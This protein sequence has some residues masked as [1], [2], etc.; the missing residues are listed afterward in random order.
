M[1]LQGNMKNQLP[2]LIRWNRAGVVRTP[3]TAAPC[4]QRDAG[5]AALL[6]P[7]V[8]AFGCERVSKVLLPEQAKLCEIV[9]IIQN[10]YSGCAT[11]NCVFVTGNLSA[12]I[13]YELW[14][15]LH[16]V[17]PQSGLMLRTAAWAVSP[18][19]L[20][21]SCTTTGSPSLHSPHPWGLRPH[22]LL[23]HVQLA[24]QHGGSSRAAV[25]HVP[26]SCV[27]K[28]YGLVQ[29]ENQKQKRSE[30]ELKVDCR[31]DLLVIAL[32]RGGARSVLPLS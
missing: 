12:K 32:Q 7:F 9:Q 6:P 1:D 26:F 17:V 18:P 5:S 19:P 13:L 10:V 29:L 28:S 11:I 15:L 24:E 31:F 20:P 16:F 30:W 8:A 22:G 4:A 14:Y 3:V 2:F 21:Q 27:L 25:E 23:L